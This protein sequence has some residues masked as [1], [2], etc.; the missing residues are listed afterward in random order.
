M[1]MK[2]FCFHKWENIDDSQYYFHKKCDKCNAEKGI[3]NI[4]FK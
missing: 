4:T 3:K 1:K 2:Y